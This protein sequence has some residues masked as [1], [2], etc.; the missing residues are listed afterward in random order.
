MAIG[1]TAT[2]KP[3]RRRDKDTKEL[4]TANVPLMLDLC[5]RGRI[6]Y[7]TGY[8]LNN[9]E[10]Y[11]IKEQRLEA[12]KK[13]MKGNVPISATNVNNDLSRLKGYISDAFEAAKALNK[14]VTA[15]YLLE[16]M[17]VRS[18]NKRVKIEVKLT[19]VESFKNTIEERAKSGL[20]GES[21]VKKYTTVLNS[22]IRYLTINKKSKIYPEDFT[23]EMIL[24][25]DEFLS[26]EANYIE[27]YRDLYKGIQDRHL[28]KNR[29]RNT[30]STL[31]KVLQSYFSELEETEKIEVTP[32]RKIAKRTKEQ[33]MKQSYDEP[34]YLTIDE[35]SLIVDRE[36]PK[37]F[38]RVRDCF[39]LQCAI[40]CRVEDFNNLTWENIEIKNGFY[41][42]HYVPAKTS[43]NE[44]L[45]TIDTPLVKFA[46]D[47]IKK[48]KNQ[49]P[50]ILA[51][52]FKGNLT[53]QD[54]YNT[55]IKKLLQ[56][57]GIDRKVVKKE[58]GELKSIPVWEVS[59]SKICRSTHV[60]ITNKV[61]VNQYVSGLHTKGSKAVDRYTSLTLKDKFQLCCVA[62]RQPEYKI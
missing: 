55:Q 59:S 17:K 43:H 28:P 24:G 33:M 35:L 1:F 42:V 14:E 62:F 30:V 50:G 10:D 54:G 38:E 9:I 12:G 8:R 34:I 51:P 47:I 22:L 36:A 6:W 57:Y 58:G 3:E 11:N 18:S 37:H 31:L 44:S 23:P 56:H 21:R 4:I 48:Y 25:F 32:F 13:A 7:N 5:Y 60:D 16:E 20:I 45:K 2:F 15:K 40:G 39:L 19:L 61:Q 49:L 46:A 29:E 53:G 27:N 41:H 52:N 26:H